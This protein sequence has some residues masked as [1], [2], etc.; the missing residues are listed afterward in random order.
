LFFDSYLDDGLLQYRMKRYAKAE[1]IFTNVIELIKVSD[2]AEL[3][4][5][6]W[7]YIILDMLVEK[8]IPPSLDNVLSKI[9]ET[10]PYLN[11]LSEYYNHSGNVLA[12][13]GKYDMATNQFTIGIQTNKLNLQNYLDLGYLICRHS[14]ADRA[15][16]M[17]DTIMSLDLSEEKRQLLETDWRF[18]ILHHVSVRP[19]NLKE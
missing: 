3:L 1:I 8:G 12:C 18:I 19:Y 9:D 5:Q 10:K 2:T 14:D 15:G 7:R 16:K 4:T 17:I 13:Y 11:D 6:D